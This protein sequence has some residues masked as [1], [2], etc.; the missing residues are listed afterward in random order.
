MV[1]VEGKLVDDDRTREIWRKITVEMN[2]VGVAKHDRRPE[3]ATRLSPVPKP[4]PRLSDA[5]AAKLL[6]LR[7]KRDVD[8]HDPSSI[9]K[10][11]G[12]YWFFSTGTG[13]SSWRSEDLRTWQRG[14]R[15]FPE[16]PR[17]VTDVVPGQRGHFWAP[18]VI[19]LD[20]RYLLYYSVSSFGR[21]R[22]LSRRVDVDIGSRGSCF[23]LDRPWHRSSV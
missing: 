21:I 10:C 23:R 13:V 14:P 7:G 9:A 6:S 4:Q 1:R 2:D 15:V 20:D 12:E 3:P 11:D 8:V 5:E 17:W 16:I 18:D 19:Q 22:R